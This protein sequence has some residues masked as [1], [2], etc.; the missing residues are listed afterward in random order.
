MVEDRPGKPAAGILFGGGCSGRGEDE[1]DPGP[2]VAMEVPVCGEPGC[3]IT[4]SL[5]PDLAKVRR[6]M[7]MGSSC[8]SV[9]QWRVHDDGEI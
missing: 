1:I 7:D 6:A 5:P 9:G 8:A 4:H 2:F 3:T